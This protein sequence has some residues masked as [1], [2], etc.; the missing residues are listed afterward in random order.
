MQ[1]SSLVQGYAHLA[2]TLAP[3]GSDKRGASM[4]VPAIF[5]KLTANLFAI[6][7][8]TVPLEADPSTLYLNLPT[9]SHVSNV[10]D[11]VGEVSSAGTINLNQQRN[12]LHCKFVS[13]FEI[14]GD[15]TSFD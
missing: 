3:K 7:V 13:S 11:F 12:G 2:S 9:I 6:P 8:P 1:V 5:E 4:Q 14:N 10:V 15:K